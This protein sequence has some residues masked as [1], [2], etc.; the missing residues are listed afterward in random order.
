MM[1]KWI[2]RHFA[3]ELPD[4]W[5]MLQFTRELSTGR[6]AFADRYNFRFEFNWRMVPGPPDFERMLSDYQSLLETTQGLHAAKRERHGSWQG[7][8]GTHGTASSSRYGRF[9]AEEGC[10]LEVVFL[11]PDTRDK[12]LEAV[13]LDSCRY[14]GNDKSGYQQWRAFGMDMQ[15]PI[16][17]EL[18]QAD[19]APASADMVFGRVRS[20]DH[21]RFRRLGLVSC[22]LKTPLEHWLRRQLHSQAHSLKHTRR[23]VRDHMLETLKGKYVPKFKLRRK[24]K[25]MVTAWQCPRDERI[26]VVETIAG[27]TTSLA[28][29]EPQ[30]LLTCC[31]SLRRS[32]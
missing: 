29:Q 31:E 2:W 32:V 11:W 28:E 16:G 24:R 10:L 7:L 1:K 5:E 27:R 22:W 17:M 20:E 26:Y 14:A 21:V 9:Y 4:E 23:S 8:S 3:F 18:L 30:S 19:I 13:I 6:C 25:Y 12:K 15:Q